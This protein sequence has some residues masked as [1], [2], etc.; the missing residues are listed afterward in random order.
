MAAFSYR[1]VDRSGRRQSGVLE[2]ASLV[3]ARAELRARGLLPIDVVASATGAS[4]RPAGGTSL[5]RRL[6]PAVGARELTLITRQ[7]ATLVGS[8]VRVE[9]ALGTVAQ[10]VRP[11]AAAVLLNVR[12]AVLDG[13]SFGRA[14]AEY[15]EVFSGF[16]R[17][18]VA[19]GE[20]SGQLEKVLRRLSTFLETRARNAQSIQ[21]ALI[22]PLILAALSFG[23]MSMLMVYVMPSITRVF[24]TNGVDLPILT[25][26]LILASEAFVSWGLPAAG[27]LALAAVG[28]RRWLRRPANRLRFHRRLARNRITSRYV[29]RISATQFTSTLAMLVES[30]VPLVEAMDAAAAVTPNLQIRKLAKA[31]A[32]NV[33]EGRT[34]RDALQDAGCFPL[35]LVA[36]AA[37]GE[38]GGN[39]GETL[40]LAAEDQ[41]RDL[42]AWVRTMV[43]L[44]EPGILL[45][46]GGL[47]MLMVLAI[48]LPIIS[49]NSLAGL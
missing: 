28:F 14:L 7:L 9:D 23:I 3:S 39:L 4:H 47:V 43:A 38:A 49:M 42:D 6:L 13:R 33:R 44:V 29:H 8:G 2:A 16:Y 35:M 37:S 26:G 12:A 36:M 31:A 40:A 46:M 30:Q 34:L 1:A 11:R 21:L 41:Q 25:R 22:Y 15:P 18:S 20:Q 48:M 27:A 10:Q 17:A 24:T 32:L 45:V 19:A 5:L